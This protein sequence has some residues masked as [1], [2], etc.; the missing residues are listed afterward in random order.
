LLGDV[1]GSRVPANQVAQF[2]VDFVERPTLLFSRR[3][4]AGLGCSGEC[5]EQQ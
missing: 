4:F 5:Y 2:A 1:S 3:L